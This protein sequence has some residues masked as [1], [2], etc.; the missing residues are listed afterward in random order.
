MH[1]KNGIMSLET[2]VNLGNPY[3]ASKYELQGKKNPG[4]GVK[5]KLVGG[6][7]EK[8]IEEEGKGNGKLGR[9]GG[10]LFLGKNMNMNIA[11]G[12]G[13]ERG[14]SSRYRGEA[15][16]GAGGGGIASGTSAGTSAGNSIGN[17]IGSI[18]SLPLGERLLRP[19]PPFF[20]DY[21]PAYQPDRGGVLLGKEKRSSQDEGLIKSKY[22][23]GRNI[24]LKD[25]GNKKGHKKSPKHLPLGN[26]GEGKTL[27]SF[28]KQSIAFV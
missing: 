24:R 15:G 5:H 3:T 6:G 13:G 28:K 2:L 1:Q 4:S 22:G 18:N 26:I 25:K 23:A 27:K 16:A 8:I 7:G 9:K 12:K 20:G 19:H 21:D 14:L 11:H 10:G 17:S